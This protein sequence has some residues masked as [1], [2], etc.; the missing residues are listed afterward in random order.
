MLNV[1]YNSILTDVGNQLMTELKSNIRSMPI[2][3]VG[4]NGTFQSVVNASGKLEKSIRF[5]VQGATLTVFGEDYIWYL[6]NGRKPTQGGGDGSLKRKIRQWIDDKGI[7]PKDNISKDSL[8]FLITRKIH[9]EGTTIWKAGGSD[10]VSSVFN[11]VTIDSIEEHFA[12]LLEAEAF[13]NIV[14]IAA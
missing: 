4:A 2:T 12:R 11:D 5:E 7:T 3:R 9:E 1:D 13:S 10:L 8:A 14:D 6:Q